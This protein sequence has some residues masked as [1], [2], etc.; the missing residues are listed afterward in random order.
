[1]SDYDEIDILADIDECPI[2]TISI[3]CAGILF[4]TEYID[5]EGT[6]EYDLRFWGTL[7]ITEAE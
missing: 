1:M 6:R 4:T 2:H 5:A 3:Y 7:P